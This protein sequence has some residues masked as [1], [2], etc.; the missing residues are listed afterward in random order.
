[1]AIC[2]ELKRATPTVPVGTIDELYRIF[3]DPAVTSTIDSVRAALEQERLALEVGLESKAKEYK[4]EANRL[5]SSLPGIIFQASSFK[6]HEWIDSKKV[7]HGMGAWRHQ[8]HV[9]M[10]GLFIVD[11]DHVE[12]PRNLWKQLVDKKAMDWNP[13]FVFVSPSGRGLKLVLPCDI[14]KGNIAANQKAFGEAFGVEVDEKCKDASRLTFV[15][16]FDDILFS[17]KEVCTYENREYVEKWNGRYSDGSADS[18][19]AFSDGHSVRHSDAEPPVKADYPEFLEDMLRRMAAAREFPVMDEY[20]NM[21]YRGL[22]VGEIINEYFGGKEPEQGERH[23]R[24]MLFVRDARHILD[25]NEKAVI[26]WTLKLGFVQ[27]LMD[28]GDNVARD[29]LDSLAYKYAPYMPQAFKKAIKK[30]KSEVLDEKVSNLSEDLINQRYME[31]GEQFKELFK[32]YPCMKECVNGFAVS[33]Y[34]AV[35]FSA[36]CMYGT[37]ATRCFYFHFHEPEQQRRLNYEV[38]VIADPASGKSGIGKLYKIIMAP[39][40]AEDKV[41]NDSINKNK[42]ARKVNDSV[43]DKER[44]KI[45]VVDSKVRIHG[46]RTANN[47]FIED[48]V[49]NVEEIDGELVHLHL[50]TFDA[51]LEAAQQASRGGQWI[52]KTIFEL[53]AF[54]NEE[55]NQQYRNVDSVSGPFDVYWN[56]VYTGTPY[57][58]YRKVN[59]RNF[60]SGL[61]TRLAVIPLAPDKYK[62]MPFNRNARTNQTYNETMKMW[63]FRMDG[64]KGELPIWPLVEHTWKWTN[65]LMN[66]AG[67]SDDEALAF[68]IKR[69]SYYGINCSVPFIMMR[70][71]EEWQEKHALTIDEKDLELCELFMEVQLFSQKHYFGKMTEKYCEN[72]HRQVEEQSSENLHTKTVA[73]L[74]QLPKEITANALAKTCDISKDYARVLIQRWLKD[75]LIIQ[76]DNKKPRKYQKTKKGEIV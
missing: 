32:Y 39:L 21:K 75:E 61:S 55:D 67:Q 47:V 46:S 29:I 50:F 15:S 54:H 8:E 43:K 69:V 27:K 63:A 4:K 16:K 17:L 62:M 14:N 76:I 71:W 5:K 24:M 70:H 74:R 56:L 37:L 64:V 73:M 72:S 25:R 23:D 26:Y 19:L 45:D 13:F 36:A 34:P 41:Y 52:D 10:N 44:K 68:L 40:I 11:I 57:S 51:E 35:L 59:E 20:E 7:N 3:K 6:E 18:C 53:K 33:S 65:D 48:M 2:A 60:G 31:F 22:P 58:L 38:F 12:N 42:K 49:N 9:M 1:M 66:I 28:E 30:F